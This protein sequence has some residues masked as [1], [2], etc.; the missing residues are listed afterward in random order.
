MAI[1]FLSGK[2]TYRLNKK[3]H[4]LLEEYN[5]QK[6]DLTIFDAEDKKTFSL[7]EALINAGTI[8]LFEE[9]NTRCIVIKNPYF[10]DPSYKSS[11]SEDKE[12]DN[13]INI[14]KS[15]LEEPN[16][17]TLLIIIC[18]LF[19][20]D[21]RKAEYK[22]FNDKNSKTFQFDVMKSWEFDNYA[23]QVIKDSNLNMNNETINEFLHRINNN[24]LLFHKELDKLLLYGEKDIT[25][26]D[27]KKLVSLNP[28]INVFE[29]CNAFIV[30]DIDR[31]LTAYNEMLAANFDA[32][33]IFF[34]LASRLRALFETKRLYENGLSEAEI[35]NRLHANAY[36]VKK[37]I[38][39]TFSVS[40]SQILSYLNDLANIDQNAK[41]GKCDLKESLEMFL[42]KNGNAYGRN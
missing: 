40:S 20:A 5:I 42:L 33:A 34:M 30:G 21:K 35:T 12:K 8:S 31:T 7:E 38:E 29:I 26:D 28:D 22:L 23:R 6:E 9:D 25:I 10:L 39:N 41:L 36:A 4:S 14:L 1:F 13:R 3:Y 18:D 17:N 11:K 32:N 2:D 19:D 37:S 24:S 15:Y 16:D 27:I